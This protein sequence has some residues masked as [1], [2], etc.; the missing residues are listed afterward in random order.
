MLRKEDPSLRSRAGYLSIEEMH[1]QGMNHTMI[2]AKLG[3]DTL[4]TPPENVPHSSVEAA[5]LAAARGNSAEQRS[6]SVWLAAE[7]ADTPG[8]GSD[9]ALG[10]RADGDAPG[11]TAS[12]PAE[13]RAGCLI[14]CI[15]EDRFPPPTRPFHV[16]AARCIGGSCSSFAKRYRDHK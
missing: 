10:F 14:V 9:T 3:V 8:A 13:D 5:A 15:V 7:S 11:K 12:W 1:Q 16:V 6:Q 2:A 4:S